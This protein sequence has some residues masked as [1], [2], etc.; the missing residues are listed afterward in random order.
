MAYLT[1]PQLRRALASEDAYAIID[2]HRLGDT[3]T[4]GGC[5]VLAAALHSI[6][7][8]SSL[9][10][11]T[12]DGVVQHVLVRWSGRYWDADGGSS[13]QAL[14][15]RWRDVEGLRA[16]RLEEFD[17]SV[18]EDSAGGQWHGDLYC[19]AGAVSDVR[20]FLLHEIPSLEAAARIAER[21][22]S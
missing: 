3:W 22:M 21:E 13:K 12:D 11:V 16:P 17:A 15:R 2:W 18:E 8:R 9:V 10:A 6:L 20:R 7:P 4:A 5:W 1:S 19:P 14:L